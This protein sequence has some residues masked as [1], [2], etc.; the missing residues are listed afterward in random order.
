VV[1]PHWSD[2]G[3]MWTTVRELDI[4]A[5]RHEAERGLAIAVIG[6]PAALAWTERLLRDGPNRYPASSDP[7]A[8]VPLASVGH[9]LDLLGGVDLLVLAFDAASP[10]DG[11]ELAGLELLATTPRPGQ[12]V[13]LFGDPGPSAPWSAYLDRGAAILVD[14]GDPAAAARVAG[15]VLDALP[16]EVRLAAARRLPGLRPRFAARLTGEVSASNAAVALASGVPS[17]LPL[18]SIPLAAADTI[19]LTKNQALMVY[20]LALASGAEP[21]FQKRML[22]ITPVIGG[23]VMWRQIAGALVGLVPGYGILPKTAVAYG[24]TYVVGLAATRWYE[25]G[26]LTE[27][28][29]K[30]LTAEAASV[31]RRAAETMVGQARTAGGKAGAL[32]QG[33]LKKAAL[34]AA[35]AQARAGK[36]VQG[37]RTATGAA[38]GKA[39]AKAQRTARS[40]REGSR[41]VVRR[42][43]PAVEDGAREPDDSDH[44]SADPS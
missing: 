5:V 16:A 26:L 24:G 30:R 3:A 32:T 17:L 36:A 10:L 8:L 1:K 13:L 27:A 37:A 29:R 7:L 41:K 18:L 42:G 14:S 39:G 4:N 21:E 22:E 44:P 31:A 20:R 40:L 11:A 19:I 34:G 33:G 28:E 25:T 2:F 23:A 6:Q 38:T 9:R 15:A 12:V 43:R 35:A